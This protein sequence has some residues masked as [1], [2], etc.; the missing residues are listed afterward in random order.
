MNVYVITAVGLTSAMLAGTAYMAFFNAPADPLAQC[1]GG[2]V[3]TGTASIGGPFELVSETGATV[4]EVDV[5][6]APTLVYFG[7][8][9][10]P[11]VCPLDAYRNGEAADLLAAEGYDVNTVFIS[12]DPARD[13][14][15]QLAFFTDAMH[16]DMLGLT[17]TDDQ[18]AQAS[19]AYKTYYRKQEGDPEY[20]LV[21]HSTFTY[22]ML[23]GQGFADFF[24][25]EDSAQQIAE[26]T[27]CFID[28]A[29]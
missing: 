18:V 24:R 13:T 14:P 20:Y 2:V 11:D 8:T 27:A 15:E 26:R 21:D 16:P 22:L 19:R 17:G 23:P 28:A 12:V 6:D 7:Y 25:R 1:R 3:A 9:F 10:C 4:T 29:S 5:I